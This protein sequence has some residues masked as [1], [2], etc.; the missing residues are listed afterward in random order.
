MIVIVQILVIIVA[1]AII[2]TVLVGKQSHA[3]RAWKKISL[4][5]LALGMII[6]VLFPD[7]TNKIANFVGVGRGADLLLYVL[8]VAFI[9]YALN[10]YLHQQRDKDTLFRLARKVALLDANERYDIHSSKK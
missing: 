9:G 4:S 6:A 3:A 8:T 5:I 10:N 7:S 1:I 2:L